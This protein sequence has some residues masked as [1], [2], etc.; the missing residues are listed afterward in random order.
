MNEIAHWNGQEK[1][2]EKYLLHLSRAPDAMSITLVRHGKP[3]FD[4]SQIV[5]KNKTM[6]TLR[7]YELSRVSTAPDD[8]LL[9]EIKSTKPYGVASELPRSRDSARLLQI[10]DP[11][12]S[13]L[14]NEAELPHPTRLMLP[15][16]WKLMLVV[17]RIG[18]LLGYKENASGITKDKQRAREAA[19]FLSEEASVHGNVIAIGHGIMNGLISRE[20][21]SMGWSACS[22][23]GR[24]YWSAT[25]MTKAVA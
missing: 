8:N 11:K 24:K 3:D 18:W 7:D 6:E 4:H 13:A 14:L 21:R 17:C 1:D 16:P 5:R 20:L 22:N 25:V 2:R 12:T 19:C 10:D 9:N 15:M 23:S